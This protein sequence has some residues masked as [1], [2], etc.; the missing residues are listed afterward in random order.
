MNKEKIIELLVDGAAFNGKEEKFYHSSFRKGWRKLTI[1]IISW[2]AVEKTHGIFGTKRL[3]KND[4][5]FTLAL[6]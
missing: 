5:I 4:A 6:V 1:H 2:Q 3:Q